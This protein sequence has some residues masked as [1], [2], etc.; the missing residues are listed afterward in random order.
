MLIFVTVSV[1]WFC[2]YSLVQFCAGPTLNNS[3]L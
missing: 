2:G 1:V 3:Y